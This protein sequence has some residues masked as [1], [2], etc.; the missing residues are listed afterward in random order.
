MFNLFRKSA[1]SKSQTSSPALHPQ[2]LQPRIKHTNFLKALH[3]AGVPPQQLPLTVPLCGEL[4]VSFAFDLPDSFMVA[5]P[6][7]LEQVGVSMAELPQLALENLKRVLPQ[8]QFFAKDNWGLAHTG[9]GLDATLLLV[10]AVWDEMQPNFTGDILCIAPRRDRIL[11]C[12][13]ANP[14]A[15]ASMR[16]HA[17]EF[18]D[19][20]D[21]AHRLSTQTMVRRAGH[22][23][24]FDSH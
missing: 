23:A 13:S 4:T 21:D 10:D 1:E 3:A 2:Q 8:P 5:T 24:L 9:Q 22:W 18:F 14:A 20:R 6:V 19:E 15:L 12:D 11:M 17:A 7:L 16:S